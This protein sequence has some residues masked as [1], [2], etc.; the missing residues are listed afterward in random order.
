MQTLVTKTFLLNVLWKPR[1]LS[2]VF[3]FLQQKHTSFIKYHWLYH[4]CRSAHLLVTTISRTI[5]FYFINSFIHL[6]IFA[7]IRSKQLIASL[8]LKLRKVQS[9]VLVHWS[10]DETTLVMHRCER[11]TQSEN[12]HRKQDSGCE[13]TV[14]TCSS[15]ASIFPF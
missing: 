13:R 14:L 5:Y 4:D 11:A 10:E 2:R 7:L 8:K 12:K 3:F 1:T 6:F 15:N 9:A